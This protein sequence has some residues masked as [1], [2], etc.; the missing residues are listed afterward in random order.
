LPRTGRAVDHHHPARVGQQRLQN[1]GQ[2]L[3]VARQ[4]IAHRQRRRHIH[5]T[6]GQQADAPLGLPQ[7]RLPRWHSRRRR[8]WPGR[9]GCGLRQGP[10]KA[11]GILQLNA[12]MQAQGVL[13]IK[14]DRG[15]GKAKLRQ[16][17]RNIGSHRGFADSTFRRAKE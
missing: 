10:G 5:L 14:I 17:R 7:K 13:R 4:R 2:P 11:G 6:E 8:A 1:A 16:S 9:N 15:D 3:R 12:E